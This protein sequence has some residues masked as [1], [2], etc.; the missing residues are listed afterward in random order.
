MSIAVVL[1][2]GAPHDPGWQAWV[3][4]LCGCATWAPTEDEVLQ[5]L[6]A[7]IDEHLAWERSHGDASTLDGPK[8]RAP[9]RRGRAAAGAGR[10]PSFCCVTYS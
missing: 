3:P 4:A 2:E 8:R 1:K 7:K 5:R 10:Q 6:P 9:R